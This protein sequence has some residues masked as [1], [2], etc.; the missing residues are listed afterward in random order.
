M[1]VTCD[2][3]VYLEKQ[4]SFVTGQ[5]NYQNGKLA[6]GFRIAGGIDQDYTLSPQHYPDS[7]R[8]T[9]IF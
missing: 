1:Y 5:S 3:Q 7:V 4:V 8:C 6:S 2:M 9:A